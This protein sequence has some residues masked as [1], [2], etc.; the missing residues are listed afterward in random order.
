MSWSTRVV[1]SLTGFVEWGPNATLQFGCHTLFPMLPDH[2]H[3]PFGEV[4]ATGFFY[5]VVGLTWGV[6]LHPQTGIVGIF[7][8]PL[9]LAH[10]LPAAQQMIW[11]LL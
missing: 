8:L 2:A 6:A 10:S 3:V 5:Q 11:S 7:S 1:I 9:W 4:T